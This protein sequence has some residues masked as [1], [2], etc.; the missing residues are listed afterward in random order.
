MKVRQILSAPRVGGSPARF[1]HCPPQTSGVP[2]SR[3]VGSNHDARVQRLR[4]GERATA[5]TSSAGR[6]GKGPPSGLRGALRLPGAS[7]EFAPCVPLPAVHRRAEGHRVLRASG[8]NPAP[9]ERARASSAMPTAQVDEPQVVPWLKKD[10]LAY[11]GPFRCVSRDIRVDSMGRMPPQKMAREPPRAPPRAP[12]PEA[13]RECRG[14]RISGGSSRSSPSF[15]SPRCGTP[16][17][18]RS[19]LHEAV[20]WAHLRGPA[21][22]VAGARSSESRLENIQCPR[23]SL[24]CSPLS[25]PS[26]SRTQG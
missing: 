5:R 14:K 19:N 24:T 21:R 2:R 7:R 17:G 10:Q 12:R 15:A 22:R 11:Y 18:E 26:T 3:A 9:I 8:A 16:P 13:H 23:V 4:A 20:G 25:P 1:A 6:D